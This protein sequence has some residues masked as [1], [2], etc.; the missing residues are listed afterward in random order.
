MA[1]IDMGQKE[2]GSNVY[3]PFAEA[4][5][6]SNTMWPGPSLTSMPSAILIRP[7]VWPHAVHERYRQD[8]QRSDSIERTVLQTVAPKT[9]RR[10]STVDT[11]GETDCV[12]ERRT[13]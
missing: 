3:A 5:T 9:A 10:S 11:G 2:R 7:T 8:R 4:G 1:T 12:S 6:P 13:H